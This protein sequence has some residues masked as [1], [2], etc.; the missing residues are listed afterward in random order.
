MQRGRCY[1]HTVRPGTGRA[2]FSEGNRGSPQPRLHPR[3]QQTGT[4][5]LFWRPPAAANV[6]CLGVRGRAPPAP[7]ATG[8]SASV[9]DVLLLS[10]CTRTTCPLRAATC[11][12]PRPACSPRWKQCFPLLRQVGEPSSLQPP[13]CPFSKGR[14]SLA[15]ETSLISGCPFTVSDPIPTIPT[16]PWSP[17]ASSCHLHAVFLRRLFNS[18]LG[19]ENRGS[20]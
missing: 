14:G 18:G 7:L 15:A 2:G 17:R 19:R 9:A 6:W 5:G 8:S 11:S 3:E 13:P 10:A 1:C 4:P 12:A 16:T 20:A